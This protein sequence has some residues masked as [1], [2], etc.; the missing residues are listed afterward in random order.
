MSRASFVWT[1]WTF[2]FGHVGHFRLGSSPSVRGAI[3]F[4]LFPIPPCP[5]PTP[6]TCR[7]SACAVLD[8]IREEREKGQERLKA[9]GRTVLRTLRREGGVTP[10]QLQDTTLVAGS[11]GCVV[12]CRVTTLGAGARG[13]AGCFR[14]CAVQMASNSCLMDGCDSRDDAFG[15]GTFG[16]AGKGTRVLG[17]SGLTKSG[18]AAGSAT[19]GGTATAALLAR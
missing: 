3:D 6:V 13:R 9:A 2:S 15:T 8:T 5:L 19:A 7:A 17:A 14:R 18:S 16:A 12:S 11:F 1:C 4:A 10:A